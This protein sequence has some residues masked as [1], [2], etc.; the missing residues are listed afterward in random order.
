V[1]RT[2]HARARF[3]SENKSNRSDRMSR[4]VVSE[5]RDDSGDDDNDNTVTFSSIKTPVACDCSS[6]GEVCPF[7]IPE[8]W[9]RVF[10]G[11]HYD[12]KNKVVET[13]VGKESDSGI[14]RFGEKSIAFVDPSSFVEPGLRLIDPRVF[15]F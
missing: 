15:F 5:S 13:P 2:S 4:L 3:E 7:G 11:R 6:I 1:F 8:R 10:R 9:R 14:A 12:K